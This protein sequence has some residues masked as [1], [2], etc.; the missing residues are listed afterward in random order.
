MVEQVGS[1]F[2]ENSQNALQCP[3]FAEVIIRNPK[4]F[5]IQPMGEPGLIQVLSALPRSYPGFS[6]LTED[7]GVLIGDDDASNGWN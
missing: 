4:D 5:S 1:V 7:I 3:N 2:M 6:L